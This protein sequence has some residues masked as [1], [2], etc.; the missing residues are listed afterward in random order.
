MYSGIERSNTPR[1]FVRMTSLAT[2]SGKIVQST[3]TPAAWIQRRRRAAGH[4]VRKSAVRSCQWKMTSVS[5]SADRRSAAL[6][7]NQYRAPVRR[8][9][10]PG[11]GASDDAPS[12]RTFT[13]DGS[14]EDLPSAI[15]SALPVS[16][17]P[18]AGSSS[19]GA[20]A[21][22]GGRNRTRS[23]PDG[24]G[25]VQR[26]SCGPGGSYSG[27]TVGRLSA[28]PRGGTGAIGAQTGIHDCEP[29]P[30]PIAVV[31]GMLVG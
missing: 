18:A 27:R 17:Q 22:L 3:P 29:A 15:V 8:S 25:P 31:V 9:G 28:A 6:F 11:G 7:A 13:P 21:Q 16:L 20:D 1:Q 12:T 10:R 19:A 14:L 24:P 30:D 23:R 26:R 2:S 4:T 5:G